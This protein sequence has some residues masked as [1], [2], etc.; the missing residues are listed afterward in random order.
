MRRRI[1]KTARM[2]QRTWV[3]ATES[4]TNV[5]SLI[6]SLTLPA[7]LGA[8]AHQ[9]PTGPA[10]PSVASTP[11]KLIFY[12][13]A[14]EAAT[15]NADVGA[16]DG[17]SGSVG[18]GDLPPSDY[19][20]IE[21]I[22]SRRAKLAE[23][24]KAEREKVQ[25]AMEA[26]ELA[27]AQG[28]EDGKGKRRRVD[29][30]RILAKGK[31][32]ERL[33][34]Q[35]GR[36]HTEPLELADS[37][38]I[39]GPKPWTGKPLRTIGKVNREGLWSHIRS[40]LILTSVEHDRVQSQIEEFRK[41]PGRVTYL[42][43]KAEPF[44]N[45]IVG[46]IGRKGLPLD[47]VIVP[48]VESG[49]EP[50]AVSPKAAAGLWQI[51]PSTGVQHGLTVSEEYDGRYDVHASTRAAL[52]YFKH[53]IGLFKGD[54][55]MALAA[56]NCGEGAVQRAI[57]A[58]A[59][60]GKGTSFWDLHLPA[61]T[62]AYVPKIVALARLIGDPATISTP[63]RKQANTTELASV[64]L[65]AQVRLAD[66]VAASGLPPEAFFRMNPAFKPD[67][68]P[69]KQA[70]TIL[71]PSD[72]AQLVAAHVPGAKFVGTKTIVVKKGDT[73]ARL[74]KKHGV[75]PIKLAEW[76]GLTTDTALTPGQELLVFPV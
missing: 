40:N 32:I 64:E 36:G 11:R 10:Q 14:G 16:F 67:V 70:Y 54:W 5:K 26:A 62:Q 74:A 59:K 21:E 29:K 73:L 43:R 69:P 4:R 27:R 42:T 57:L 20:I 3:A 75:P 53:L 48:M 56:Y 46:E 2:F 19:L 55:L 24:E 71:L 37:G 49:F 52:S 30:N 60:A 25:T 15:V 9:A 61:E 76:N 34:M 12:S 38:P 58:N 8:C 72:N 51:I 1:K 28:L 35:K 44:L 13:R 68:E 22:I 7:L 66:A 47:L 31:L 39:A 65:G 33:R 41:H 6:T 17:G 45:H 18:A 63:A 50:T 23:Q